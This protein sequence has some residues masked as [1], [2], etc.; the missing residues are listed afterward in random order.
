[1]IREAFQ[2]FERL[3]KIYLEILILN[4]FTKIS[5]HKSELIYRYKYCLKVNFVKNM[6]DTKKLES[7]AKR[8][9]FHCKYI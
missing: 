7:L 5:R 6:P 2:A 4:S 1:M 3:F 8:V 9:A